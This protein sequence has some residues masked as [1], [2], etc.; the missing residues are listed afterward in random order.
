MTSSILSF[1]AILPIYVFLILLYRNS[2][3][4][5][6]EYFRFGEAREDGGKSA[7]DRIKELATGYLVGL[8]LVIAIIA[9][10][11]TTGLLLLGIKLA[12]PL[13]IFSA[14]LTIVPY[15]GVVVGAAM[16]TLIALITKDSWWYPIGVVAVYSFVQFLEGNFITPKIVGS[17]VDIN[18]LAAIVGLLAG[19]VLWGIVGMILAIPLLGIIKVLC[20]EI[21]D[22]RPFAILLN[23]QR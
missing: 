22:L 5:F 17:K 7:I 20:E 15:V 13:G 2:F 6:L 11:N 21:P 8:L 10:L 3:K 16:P 23:E 12:I 14:L 4:R 1:F 18:P 9:V 19:G